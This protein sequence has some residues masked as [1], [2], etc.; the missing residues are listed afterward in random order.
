M[1]MIK[2]RKLIELSFFLYFCVCVCPVFADLEERANQNKRSSYQAQP[3][4]TGTLMNK[5]NIEKKKVGQ[6]LCENQ[7]PVIVGMNA[8][9]VLLRHPI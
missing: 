8:E 1:Y 7:E 6:V 2:K 9:A 5:N 3:S 4:I